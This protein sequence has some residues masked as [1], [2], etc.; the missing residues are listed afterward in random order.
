MRDF[1][2]SSLDISV[3]DFRVLQSSETYRYKAAFEG[4]GR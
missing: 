2:A 3:T 1:L 4:P